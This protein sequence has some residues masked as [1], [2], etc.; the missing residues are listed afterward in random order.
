[1]AAVSIIVEILPLFFNEVDSGKWWKRASH[2]N[3]DEFN[4][5]DFSR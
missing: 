2:I 1:M 5:I 4:N 3:L